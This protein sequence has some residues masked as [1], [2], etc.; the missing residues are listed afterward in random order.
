MTHI[1]DLF[2][3]F[4]YTTISSVPS[5][6]EYAV[7]P[8]A[9]VRWLVHRCHA[10]ITQC[11]KMTSKKWKVKP[12]DAM[13]EWSPEKLAKIQ[14]SHITVPLAYR[15]YF[16]KNVADLTL[17]ENGSILFD[18]STIG[19]WVRS[20]ARLLD[21]ADELSDPTLQQG[22]TLLRLS[23]TLMVIDFFLNQKAVKSAFAD[24][25]LAYRFTF[26]YLGTQRIILY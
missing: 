13:L 14:S 10:Q 18:H 6:A 12:W 5:S 21:R 20:L 1:P 26:G 17:E 9:F 4:R 2:A 15:A 19:A 7:S 24:T 22:D 16:R 25:S 11:F 3:A 23:D 8:P